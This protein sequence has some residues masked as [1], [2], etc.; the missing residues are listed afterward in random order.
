[1]AGRFTATSLKKLEPNRKLADG[2][3]L[4]LVTD[5][6]AVGRWFFIFSWNGRRPEMALGPLRDVSLAEARELAA[7]ARRNVREDV[8]PI[9]AR[10]KAKAI[11]P[12][13]GE[14]AD[15]LFEAKK[16][17]WRSP[18][19]LSQWRRSIEVEAATLRPLLVNAIGT[20][21]VLAVL[22]PLW[23]TK[24]ETARRLRQ[25]IEAVL[26]A[27]TAQNHRTGENPAR[28]RGHLAHLLANKQKVEG[29]HYAA[30]PYA[31]MPDFMSRLRGEDTIAAYALEYSILTASR[32]G[33]VYG[34]EWSEIDLEAMVWTVPPQRMKSGRA[35]RVP[36]SS[37]AIE[38]L[39]LMSECQ[40]SKFVFPGHIDG[41]SLS[42]VAMG[43]VIERLGVANATPHGFRSAFRD[44]AGNETLFDPQVCEQALAHVIGGVE[45]A[46]RRSDAL[47]KRR[48]L[49]AAWANH[50]LGVV[51]ESNVISMRR[52]A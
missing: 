44:W 39:R 7:A 1:M 37:R 35:H 45:G 19:H 13:F 42:R 38:I 21:D 6:K 28:W 3:G 52:G 9:A 51:D 23:L 32:P 34:A 22:K 4:Y 15:A 33:E 26:D 18:V 50:C 24:P 8:N 46:Y 11:I 16:S 30:L 20:P 27:A 10:K 12:T 17:E 14:A 40:V 43:K 47:D 36:L 25:R 31:Q 49:M 29:A 48:A 41:K 5:A 2:G